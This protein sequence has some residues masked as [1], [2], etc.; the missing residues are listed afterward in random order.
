MKKISFVIL[1]RPHRLQQSVAADDVV[2]VIRR[3]F[4]TE[5]PTDARRRSASRIPRRACRRHASS[6][7][8]AQIAL[9]KLAAHDRLAVAFSSVSMIN[10]VFAVLK[11][12]LSPCAIR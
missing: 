4:F 9:N 1:W 10:N 12:A 8:P 2:L 5:S 7:R 11:Q 6:R 3:R